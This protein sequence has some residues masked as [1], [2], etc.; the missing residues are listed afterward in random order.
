MSTPVQDGKVH[1]KG[2]TVS[3]YRQGDVLP[4]VL[5]LP[6]TGLAGDELVATPDGVVLLSQ[7]CDIIQANRPTVQVAPLI[8][9]LEQ[10]AM[11]ARGGK[12]PRYAHVPNA[13][14]D[15]F[16]DLA[17][18]ATLDKAFLAAQTRYPGVTTDKDGRRFSQAIARR[19][20]RFAFP[21]DITPWLQ[22]LQQ[23]LSKRSGKPNSPE[24]SALKDVVQLRI[25]SSAEWTT[26]PCELTLVVIVDVGTLPIFANDKL[27][28]L[29][30]EL[31]NWLYDDQGKLRR[32]SVDIAAKLQ[33]ASDPA[34]RYFYWMALGDSWAARCFPQGRQS[35]DGVGAVSS[36]I[37]EVVP[38][39]EYPLSRYLTSEQ[40]DLDYLSNVPTG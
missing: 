3:D 27:P 5:N 16:A 9:L 1:L 23:L 28:D 34:E 15:L 8:R 20:G 12:R 2:A 10:L 7:T 21:D 22:P 18:I 11:E 6:I 25:E 33:S 30:E 4:S 19:F 32:N 39:D 38:I 24:G 35:S 17:F 37:A 13:G 36:I 40:L 29:P 31:S 26:R 14:I